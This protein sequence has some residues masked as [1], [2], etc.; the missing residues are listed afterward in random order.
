MDGKVIFEYPLARAQRDGYF[1]RIRFEPVYEVDP[2]AADLAIATA[3]VTLFER[4]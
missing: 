4:I 1:K 2:S 3:A